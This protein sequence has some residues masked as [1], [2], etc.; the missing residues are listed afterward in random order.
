M[1]IFWCG[2]THLLQFS[3]I[4]NWRMWICVENST[5]SP[6][7]GTFCKSGAGPSKLLQ[8]PAFRT[9][10]ARKCR[11]PPGVWR[12]KPPVWIDFK[13][14]LGYTSFVGLL[15]RAQYGAAWPKTAH[16]RSKTVSEGKEWLGRLYK[17]CKSIQNN[18][19]KIVWNPRILAL[20]LPDGNGT[21]IPRKTL[22][23]QV[24]QKCLEVLIKY[25]S[26]TEHETPFLLY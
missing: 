20:T 24:P 2:T 12:E 14:G 15:S 25:E 18:T 13:Q 6:I 4:S 23:G 16:Y 9:L 10:S 8:I 26:R 5:V 22:A 1:T 19:I 17:R 3:P 11:I 7:P 21:L